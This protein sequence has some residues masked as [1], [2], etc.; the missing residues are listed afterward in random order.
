MHKREIFTLESQGSRDTLLSLEVNLI[1]IVGP[2]S[3]DVILDSG[4]SI[5][6]GSHKSEREERG[7]AKKT[8]NL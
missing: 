5:D 2:L 1:R 7:D 4:S 3:K 8:D 6:V